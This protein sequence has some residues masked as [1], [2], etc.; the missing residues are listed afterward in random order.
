MPRVILSSKSLW[1]SVAAFK[2]SGRCRAASSLLSDVSVPDPIAVNVATA[3][4]LPPSRRDLAQ[5]GRTITGGDA[6]LERPAWRGLP[7]PI[8]ARADVAAVVFVVIQAHPAGQ[9]DILRQYPFILDEQRPLI[10]ADLRQVRYLIAGSIIEFFF[11]IVRTQRHDMAR[12]RHHPLRVRHRIGDIHVTRLVLRRFALHVTVEVESPAPGG[13]YNI[14]G[15]AP[16]GYRYNHRG[17]LRGRICRHGRTIRPLP[18]SRPTSRCSLG[19][20]ENLAVRR[21]SLSS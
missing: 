8:Q 1:N 13:V 2:P 7:D 3:T 9:R 19:V 10:V 4:D 17:G 21:R 6:A 20:S 11:L 12:Q 16:S 15:H 5:T 14:P 18:T